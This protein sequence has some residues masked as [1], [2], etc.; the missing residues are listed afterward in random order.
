MA[1][2]FKPTL[3]GLARKCFG[4]KKR[5]KKR[6]CSHNDSYA[7]IKSNVYALDE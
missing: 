2:Q 4:E 1:D 7:N 5:K 3:A 6:T